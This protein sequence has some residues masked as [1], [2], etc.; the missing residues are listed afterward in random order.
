MEDPILESLIQVTGWEDITPRPTAYVI[1]FGMKD[2]QMI[3]G[4]HKN[5]DTFYLAY[6][7]FNDVPIC[8]LVEGETGPVWQYWTLNQRLHREDGPAY[9]AYNPETKHMERHFHFNGLLHNHHGP[10]V[11]I[12]DDYDIDVDSLP[13]HTVE[14]WETAEF[15]WMCYG[16]NQKLYGRWGYTTEG[17]CYRSKK[18]R[19][20]E[21]PEGFEPTFS[22]AKL[23]IEWT[24]WVYNPLRDKDGIVPHKLVFFEFEEVWQDGELKSRNCNNLEG[25]W[26]YQGKMYSWHDDEKK[27]SA[28]WVTTFT[29][30]VRKNLLE[31][32]S[33]WEGPIFA[34][35]GIEFLFLT[36]FN[37][38]YDS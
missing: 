7:E 31:D 22:A 11:E 33:I 9:V 36:E 20:F 13:D 3:K 19:R 21:A 10:A 4:L 5:A 18:N 38:C 27:R 2:R 28:P 16:Q 35:A 30:R 25:S 26:L 34:D 29:E 12:Y 17:Q 32:L 15:R 37:S 24:D 23:S 8:F 1:R 14:T 6:T